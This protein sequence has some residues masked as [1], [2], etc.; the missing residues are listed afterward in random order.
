MNNRRAMLLA[1]LGIIIGLAA[2]N[3]TTATEPTTIPSTVVI[4]TAEPTP[5]PPGYAPIFEQAACP[6]KLPPGQV[7]GRTVECGYLIVPEDRSDPASLTIRLAVAIFHPPGRAAEP[8][9][10]IYLMG[11]PGASAL[12]FL[13]LS[14]D[15]VFAPVFAARR[16]LIL[17]DQRGVGFSE[18]ALDCPEAYDL[19]LELLDNELDGKQLTDEE[20]EELFGEAFTAC[21]QDLGTVA[22]LSAY[23]TVSNAA[24]VNDLRI[25]LGHDQV[26]LWGGS[27]GTRL[28]L[29]VMREYLAGVRS[30]VL[31][32]V[33]PPDK[34]LYLETPANLD[35]S[36]ELFFGACA[37]DKAC[38]TAFPNLR[39]VF[40]DTVAH[41]DE[42]PVA[43]VI[44]NPMTGET[45]AML[46]SG[47]ALFGLIFQ[48]LYETE[49]LP[50]LPQLIYEAKQGDFTTI[51]RIYGA[52]VAQSTISSRGMMFSVQ[53]NE[54][55]AFST[56]EQFEAVL[57]DYPDLAPFLRDT[58]LGEAGYDVCTYWDA[59]QAEASENEPVT[60][61]IPALVMQGE[62]DPITPPAWGQRA[63]ETLTNSYF[64][65]YPGVG[66]GASVAE[67]PRQMMIAFIQNPGA[68]PSDACMAEMG[69]ISFSVPEAAPQAIEMAPF[70]NSVKGL[71]GVAPVGWT[72]AG[73]AAYARGSSALDETA[74][75]M[76][77]TSSTAREL[78]DRL[79]GSMGFDPN[80]ESV[81]RE[82]LGHFIWDL[83]TFE[84]QGLAID[85]AL[86][87][88][89][90]QAYMVLLASKPDERDGLYEQVFLPAVEALA[91]L[92]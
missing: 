49:A 39:Q 84:Y 1:L 70:T 38:N 44:T 41:L 81:G 55:L 91:S 61:D 80:L 3:R 25:A 26:N 54:E 67:C 66:H 45:H 24:D 10:I 48:L 19:G 92:E 63:A 88:D 28:A 85:L 50:V 89:D 30:V 18:P 13:Y 76:D 22:D 78:L 58:I 56:L 14:F 11:G 42:A 2:C 35:R 12:E 43:T 73:P 75:I 6:F 52:L 87:E 86:A 8:D 23:N 47:D 34:D 90:G 79:A 71:Q 7:E 4:G 53:C 27:Y 20:S 33:Y 74:L 51:S 82:E 62:Y 68:A 64:Y 65:L 17:F 21:A 37:D 77:A 16:D 40:F 60:S 29:G 57:L 83:Y 72:E 31:D 9:P 32:S 46:L 15:K 5:P 69:E 59:G 36:L